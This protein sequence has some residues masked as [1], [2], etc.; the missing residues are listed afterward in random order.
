MQRR[1]VMGY[2]LVREAEDHAAASLTWRERFALSVLANAAMDDTRECPHG[3]EDNPDIVR[4]L[5]LSR[6]ARYEVLA[7]LCEKG[8]LIQVERGRNGVK[9]VYAIA[10]FVA[11]V[12]LKGP[13]NPDATAPGNDSKRPGNPEPSAV[14]NKS[15][16]PGNP[17]ASGPSKGPGDPDA[18][19]AEESGFPGRK[20]PGNPD[21]SRGDTVFFRGDMI[22]TR[23][24]PYPRARKAIRAAVPDATDGEIDETIRGIKTRFNPRH[25]ERY[26]LGIIRRGDLME[27]FPCGLG[28]KPHSN[29]CRNRNCGKCTA[30]WCEGRCHSRPAKEARSA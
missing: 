12:H 25:T 23:S 29:D 15:K 19:D 22:E 5:R 30:P 14:D 3:I 10:P 16:G 4:R 21:P 18:R 1:A 28:D 9:A 13:G 8:A 27:H 17:D 2:Q 6:S 24:I 7:A 11:L 20:G 26:V